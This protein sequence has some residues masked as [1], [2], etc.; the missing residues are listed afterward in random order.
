MQ[1]I[2][3]PIQ[4]ELIYAILASTDT[5]LMVFKEYSDATILAQ[6][7]FQKKSSAEKVLNMKNDLLCVTRCGLA[8]LAHP[9]APA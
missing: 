6:V 7:E 3:L 5:L 1:D 8:L 9:L 4:R 2:S